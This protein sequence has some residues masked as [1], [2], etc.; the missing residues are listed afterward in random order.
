MHGHLVRVVGW[1]IPRLQQKHEPDVYFTHLSIYLSIDLSL[2][3]WTD[4]YIYRGGG[5]QGHLVRVVDGLIPRLQQKHEP[6]SAR[7]VA[8]ESGERLSDGDEVLE[9]LCH[10]EPLDVQVAEVEEVVDPLAAAVEGLRLARMEPHIKKRTHTRAHARAYTHT[11][12][13]RERTYRSSR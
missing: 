10:L 11:N 5:M 3:R 13:E 2:D 9:R 7:A 1:L 12:I 4:I 8:S 6:D